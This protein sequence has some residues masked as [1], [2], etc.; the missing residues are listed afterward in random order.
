MIITYHSWQNKNRS[1][2]RFYFSI[3]A[4]LPNYY[5]L[6]IKER[7]RKYKKKPS[8]VER[9]ALVVAIL[10]IVNLILTI[11]EKLIK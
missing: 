10:S 2:E 6:T 9:L 5:S 11:I 1:T 4:I 8:K 7:K 3:L